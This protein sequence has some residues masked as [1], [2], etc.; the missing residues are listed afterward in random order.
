MKEKEIFEG[1]GV[2][3]KTKDGIMI[4][5]EEK[6]NREKVFCKWCLLELKLKNMK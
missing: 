5:G 1:C 4:C 6:K 2:L 3:F